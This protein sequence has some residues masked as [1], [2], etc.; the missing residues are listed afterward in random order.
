MPYLLTDLVVDRVDLVNEGANSAAFIEICKRKESTNS[1]EYSE[2]LEKLK[3]EHA[4]VIKN[5]VSKSSEELTKATNDLAAVTEELSKTKEDLANANKEL[6]E[7]KKN[8]ECTC[9]GEADENGICKEC[10]RAKKSLGFD[11]AE[12]LKAMPEAA[13]EAF[14]TLRSQKEAAEEQVR[15]AAEDKLNA[16]AVSKAATLKSLPVEQETLVDIIKSCDSKVFDVL[17]AVAAAI[18]GT[19]LDEVGSVGKGRTDSDAW[20]RL[21]AEADKISTRDSVT[22]QKA[23]ATAIKEHPELYREYLNGGAN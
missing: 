2:I 12:V 23:I 16:E 8:A 21:E 5:V 17:T 14:L 15:K 13:R 18:D 20:S 22:K 7:L 6:E 10:G 3:P 9:E 1:M 11:E 4:D 19:V